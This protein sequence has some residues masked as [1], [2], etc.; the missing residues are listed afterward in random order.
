MSGLLLF[1]LRSKQFSQKALNAVILTLIAFS[2]GALFGDTTIHILPELFLQEDHSKSKLE[3]ALISLF[4]ILGFSLFVFLEIFFEKIGITH[5]HGPAD[6]SH[7]EEHEGVSP[8][9][10]QIETSPIENKE[11]DEDLEMDDFHRKQEEAPETK[12][13]FSWLKTIFTLKG[14]KTTGIMVLIAD[15][16]HNSM[17]GIAIGVAFA[18]GKKEIALSTFIAIMAHE[19]PKEIS[20]MG[21]LVESRFTLLQAFCCNGILN[22]T[23]MIGT[24]VGL[25][26]GNVSEMVN[27]YILGFVAGNFL[28]ISLVSMLPIVVKDRRNKALMGNFLAFMAGVGSQFALLAFE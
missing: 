16:L 24:L 8:C 9:S 25:S 20:G 4:I 27:K 19:I 2:V 12:G 17:D 23:A 22:F 15:F 1:I 13:K 18:S 11:L 7:N 28:Y 6:L 26:V 14:R 3:P 10:R 5:S 21:V